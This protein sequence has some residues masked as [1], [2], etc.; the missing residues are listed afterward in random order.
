MAKGIRKDVKNDGNLAEAAHIK[1]FEDEGIIRVRDFRGDVVTIDFNY[2][3]PDGDVLTSPAKSWIRNLIRDS[4]YRTFYADPANCKVSYIYSR[5]N[6]QLTWALWLIDAGVTSEDEITDTLVGEFFSLS[7]DGVDVL[8]DSRRKVWDVLE[9]IKKENGRAAAVSM[10]ASEIYRVA[11]LS[12]KL[13]THLQGAK[14][15][16]Q[17]FKLGATHLPKWKGRGRPVTRGMLSRKAS[18]VRALHAAFRDAGADQDRFDS[19]ATEARSPCSAGGATRLIPHTLAIRLLDKAMLWV[20]SVNPVLVKLRE[21][22]R[23]GNSEN[24]LATEKERRRERTAKRDPLTERQRCIDEANAD[25]KNVLGV[26]LVDGRGDGINILT[27]INIYAPTADWIVTGGMTARRAGELS[28]LSCGAVKGDE[29]SGW[30]LRTYIGKTLQRTDLTPC[31]RIVVEAVHQL[32]EFSK[33]VRKQTGVETLMSVRLRNNTESMDFALADNIN[34]FADLVDARRYKSN[35]KTL[36]WLYA[37]HQLRKL[38][39]VWY[40]W[41]YDAGDIY[42]LGYHLRHFNI[43]MT[44]RYCYDNEMAKEIAA[45]TVELTKSKLRDYAENSVESAGIYAKTLKKLIERAIGTIQLVADEML[46]KKLSMLIRERG[47]ALKATPWGFCACKPTPSNMRRAACQKPDCRSS[48]KDLD[49]R[50]DPSG[51]DEVRCAGCLFFATD[52]TRKEHWGK[53]CQSARSIVER[54]VSS[55]LQIIK[56]EKRLKVLMAVQGAL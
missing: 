28:S 32:E 19:T 40:V 54:A 42:A 44:M 3:C 14:L 52:S 21:K 49:G 24:A 9:R 30:W 35:D 12:S 29:I 2:L 38:F 20:F 6:D 48:A 53:E 22:L 27:A 39:A 13:T 33:E 47:I 37:P 25:L 17:Q 15:A 26:P 1:E 45:Q 56:F 43:R 51:S 4:I 10:S 36:N 5:T 46:D 7:R 50:P 18:A 8:F 23:I 34:K 31:P 55:R 16:I 11:C 41:R